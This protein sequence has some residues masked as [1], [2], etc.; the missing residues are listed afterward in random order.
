M[1]GALLHAAACYADAVVRAQAMQPWGDAQ[2]QQGAMAE[3]Q[4]GLQ[5]EAA[6][7]QQQAQ[8]QDSAQPTAQQ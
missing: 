7:Q 8:P 4:A 3:H 6:E 1:Y 2:S 5:Q